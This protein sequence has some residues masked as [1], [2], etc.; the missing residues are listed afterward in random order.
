M[1]KTL[2]LNEVLNVKNKIE[3]PLDEIKVIDKLNKGI[4]KIISRHMGLTIKEII[5]ILPKSAKTIE[6][7]KPHEIMDQVLAEHF[8]SLG[9]VVI[10]GSELFADPGTFSK[11][12][13]T[14]HN[15]LSR[16][17]PY[18]LLRTTT[19]CNIVIDLLGRTKHGIHS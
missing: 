8:L 5:E 11:W 9:K 7:L 6:R 14:P 4:L 12:L 19:G 18:E 1:S 16:L 2:V 17:E 3:S 15:V 10:E 13:K